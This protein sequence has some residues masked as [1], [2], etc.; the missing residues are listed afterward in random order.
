M[1]DYDYI[2]QCLHFTQ[3]VMRQENQAKK[4]VHSEYYWVQSFGAT[5]TAEYY[6]PA[7]SLNLKP[8]RIKRY[9]SFFK[10]KNNYN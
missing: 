9:C 2:F 1:Q 10:I 3:L 8:V 5:E 7:V 4:T 6:Q